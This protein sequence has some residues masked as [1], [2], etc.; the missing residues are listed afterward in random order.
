MSNR[1][2]NY[3]GNL[4]ALDKYLSEIDARDRKFQYIVDNVKLDIKNV[5]EMFENAMNEFYLQKQY[6][7]RVL[8]EK[9][10]SDDDSEV[11]QV[12]YDSADNDILKQMDSIDW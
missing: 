9:G 11:M 10:L 7:A 6:I 3:D 2:E 8:K 12:M 1:Y 5:V 4:S